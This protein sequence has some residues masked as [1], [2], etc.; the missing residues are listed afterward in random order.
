MLFLFKPTKFLLYAN[1]KTSK[2]TGRQVKLLTGCDIVINCT[3]YNMST[4]KPV[5]DVKKDGVVLADDINYKYLGY[6]WNKDDSILTMTTDMDSYE[7]YISCVAL[8][9]DGKKETMTYSSQLGGSAKRTAIGFNKD[10]E[11]IVFCTQNSSNYMTMNQIQD[12]MYTAG[13]INALN[14]DGGGS[15]QFYSNLYGE[16]YSSR[17]VHNFLCIWVDKTYGVCPYEQ[18]SEVLKNG[19]TGFGVRWL[20][21]NLNNLGYKLS[22]DGS[23]GNLTLSALKLFQK[24]NSLVIDGYCGPATKKKIK[25]LVG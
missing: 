13:C 25:E 18:P 7:N 2:K 1:T 22:I 10:N 11:L 19:Q 21:W 5:C 20:Q 8:L 6:G 12:K 23:F 3:L 9:K 16:I 15:T 4:Y 17:V 14:L 24:N